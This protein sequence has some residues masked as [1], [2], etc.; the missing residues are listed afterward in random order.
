MAPSAPPG[1]ATVSFQ[2]EVYGLDLPILRI[3]LENESSSEMCKC[4]SALH[5]QW[6][7]S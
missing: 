1:S 6:I 5:A 2:D 7:L 3:Q 4:N